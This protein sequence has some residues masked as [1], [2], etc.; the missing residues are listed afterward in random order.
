VVGK[1]CA[2]IIL[3]LCFPALALAQE[4]SAF[5]GKAKIYEGEGGT[6]KTVDG[7]DFWDNG[8]PPR[9]FQLIGFITDSRYESGWW[10]ALAMDNL[11]S[12]VAEVAKDAGGDAV[13]A[14]RSEAQSVG[15]DSSVRKHHSK[16]AVI[17]Y[18]TDDQSG[19][20]PSPWP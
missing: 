18:V 11:E 16:F 17:K 20:E 1:I 10:G 9:K 3:A 2:L 15:G 19:I 8:A 13:I 5:E 12:D 7:I 4:F 6:R 14:V